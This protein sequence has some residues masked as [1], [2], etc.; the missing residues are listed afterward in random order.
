MS[1]PRISR[2][3]SIAR[4]HWSERRHYP[5]ARDWLMSIYNRMLIHLPS[6]PLPGR[7][8]VW[9]IDS[10]GTAS[11]PIAVRLG[12]SDW[13]VAEEI[14][15]HGEY[16]PLLRHGLNN[17][18]SV[19]DLGANVGMS[20][21]LWQTLWPNVRVVAVEP[22]A[23][24]LDIARQNALPA[25]SPPP[26]FLQACVAGRS[27][28]VHLNRT[29]DAYGFK[30]EDGVAGGEAI[31]ALTVPEIC[32]RGGLSDESA[33]DLLKC[34]VEGAEAEIFADCQSWAHRVRYMAI[35]VHEPYSAEHLLAD[36]QRAGGSPIWREVAD[37]GGLSVVFL[38][39]DNRPE[40]TEPRAKQSSAIPQDR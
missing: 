2:L 39:F 23:K 38:Q 3:R 28:M 29:G 13:Y 12:S 30:M 20:V 8:R 34:D 37:K 5:R 9:K 26:V 7:G 21:R 36:L 40:R 33:I 15:L 25:S 14:F 11:G 10:P 4:R 27:R 17:V 31:E 32:G 22:D 35:E 1:I 6:L 18:K 16:E 19:L 24:N